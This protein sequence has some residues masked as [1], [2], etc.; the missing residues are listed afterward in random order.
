MPIKFGA[1]PVKP[2]DVKKVYLGDDLVYQD[3]SLPDGYTEVEYITSAGAA[4]ASSGVKIDQ[5]C[6]I[7]AKMR[8]TTSNYNM[9]GY[10][11]TNSDNTASVTH[12]LTSAGVNQRFGA[13]TA[14]LQSSLFGLKP[15]PLWMIV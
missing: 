2:P 10:G 13:Q 6:E 14:S 8:R 4:F 11:A 9:Y 7:R 5:D 1:L 15:C 3:F 12:Y